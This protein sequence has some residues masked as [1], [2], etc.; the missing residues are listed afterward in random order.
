MQHPI[1]GFAKPSTG[2]QVS[3]P[4][5]ANEQASPTW[6]ENLEKEGNEGQ[7]QVDHLDTSELLGNIL[8]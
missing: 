3:T 7:A 8:E 6:V 4:D 1:P 2:G 5:D